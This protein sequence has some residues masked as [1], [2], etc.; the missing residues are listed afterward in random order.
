[1]RR[2]YNPVLRELLTGLSEPQRTVALERERD[3]IVT[4][5]AGSGKTHTLVLRYLTLL[6]EG[7]DPEEIAA[8]TF[9]EKA[10]REM[11]F[12]VRRTLNEIIRS[13]RD[14]AER[15]KWQEKLGGVDSALIGTIHALCARILRGSFAEAGLDP[16]FTVL[17]ENQ[18]ALLRRQLVEEWLDAMTERPELYPLFE[19]FNIQQVE[20]IFSD[21][22][23]KRQEVNEIF[24]QSVDVSLLVQREITALL[25]D[26]AIRERVLQLTKM[27]PKT[28]LADAGD[29][30]TAQIDDFL[31]LWREAQDARQ[32]GDPVNALRILQRVYSEKMKLNVGKT[33][34][35]AKQ[36]LKELR[37]LLAA[38]WDTLL[39]TD[40][41][42]AG[43]ADRQAYTAL[44]DL[45]RAAA[46]GLIERYQATLRQRN[47]L[48]FDD[49]EEKALRVLQ[50][51]S[52]RDYWQG[53]FRAFLVDEFQ[54]TN[55]R[56]R[57][58]I[59]LLTSRPGQFF[60]VGDARQSIYRF[61][62]ADVT[63]FRLVQRSIAASGGLQRELNQ[64]YRAHSE[65]LDVSGDFLRRAM[66]SEAEVTA[67]Y[68]IPF[69]PLQAMRQIP[70]GEES[71]AHMAFL[72]GY[73][74]LSRENARMAAAGLLA[75]R[76]HEAMRRGDLK[77][78]DEVALLFRASSGFSIYEIA[79]QQAGI[80]YVTISGKG[81]YARPE[82]RDVLN[83][84]RAVADPY[85]DLALAGFLLS[86]V[87]GL[88][89]AALTR[90]R[91]PA[92]MDGAPSHFWNALQQDLPDLE[93]AD[94]HTLDWA[95]DILQEL[96][97]LADRVPVD[98]LIA[99]LVERTGYRVWL[100][101]APDSRKGRNL[102]KLISDA[103]KSGLTLVTDFLTFIESL[104][105]AGAR[106]GEAPPDSAGA[107]Q[108]MTIHKSKGLEFPCVVL[109]DAGYSR[110]PQTGWIRLSQTW[111]L[112]VR[113][114]PPSLGYALSVQEERQQEEAELKRL[115]Y[116]AMTRARER[117]IVSGHFVEKRGLP[118]W[119]GTLLGPHEKALRALA[120]ATAN[121]TSEETWR[122]ET[123]QPYAVAVQGFEES[124][125]PLE[126]YP[127]PK[128]P[129]LT[130]HPIPLWTPLHPC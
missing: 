90:L 110:G 54:D 118:G 45:L 126:A 103:Q 78:W 82:V 34:S 72:L 55:R 88:S 111:G 120:G 48:D 25:D 60:A 129:E 23:E 94:R 112:N 113:T 24:S 123:G 99:T 97:P 87:I 63:V 49:L 41:A 13:N 42:T 116:V 102:D 124:A 69:S 51:P 122:T 9:T 22:L 56:Q 1:M 100:A 119:L 117:L 121:G 30:L 39:S 38:R 92:R 75:D 67:G 8:I 18:T 32:A 52:V 80:P 84:L 53:R 10:A 50:I 37:V 44:L 20:T 15:E 14:R 85:D 65:L 26:A 86:P 76:L 74:P 107:V 89:K 64:T 29:K 127:Q 31:R 7:F 40:G 33:A 61:R 35:S 115:L 70:A 114:D 6:D 125:G 27:D 68:E 21:L 36:T 130:V 5:G 73:D 83:M 106:E 109:A 2:E 81:F 19:E 98:D 58:L 66:G 3:V 4:A 95:G 47:A 28:L 96:I 17:D 128:V 62:G 91:W 108:L 104:N 71:A 79:L 16:A 105:D 46:Q 77:S 59:E 101:S 57:S 43:E 93:D 11:K 12:R